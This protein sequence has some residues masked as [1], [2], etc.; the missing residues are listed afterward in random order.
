MWHSENLFLLKLSKNIKNPCIV[1]RIS[2]VKIQFNIPLKNHKKNKI[3]NT[4]STHLYIYMSALCY[5][6]ADK[7][8]VNTLSR[9]RL[10]ETLGQSIL[11]NKSDIKWLIDQILILIPIEYTL[12]NG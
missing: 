4:L 5:D 2:V 1:F 8:S 11:S 7:H 6:R 10:I 3:I 9:D 12:D